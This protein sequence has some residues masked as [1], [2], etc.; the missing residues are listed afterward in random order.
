MNEP[1]LAWVTLIAIIIL[2]L[3]QKNHPYYRSAEKGRSSYVRKST[4]WYVIG[5]VLITYMLF[6]TFFVDMLKYDYVQYHMLDSHVY[7]NNFFDSSTSCGAIC[8][9]WTC[10]QGI[11]SDYSII[12]M[13]C[14]ATD[15]TCTKG[16]GHCDCSGDNYKKF[17]FSADEDPRC[18]KGTLVMPSFLRVLGL[19]SP[20]FGIAGFVIAF[21]QTMKYV[22]A[23][24]IRL[25][26]N[27]KGED[28]NASNQTLA[29][30][31]PSIPHMQS[32]VMGEDF[33]SSTEFQL[34]MVIVGMP[35]VFIVLS[36]RATIRV[37]AVMTG[38]C[39]LG[40]TK[41]TSFESVMSGR[42]GAHDWEELRGTW[43]EMKS[44]EVATYKQDLEVA[45]GFQFFA[46][47]CYGYV[48][49]KAFQKIM[50][51]RPDT[52]GSFDSESQRELEWDQTLLQH[53]GILG[54]WAFTGLGVLKTIINLACQAGGV[55][56]ASWKDDIDKLDEAFLDKMNMMFLLATVLSIVNMFVVGKMKAVVKELGGVNSKFNATRALLLIGQGQLMVLLAASNKKNLILNAIHK[57]CDIKK[58]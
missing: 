21:L 49:S 52:D 42:D 31:A 35:L 17:P 32:V 50:R 53:A 54:I 26:G 34:R 7:F 6:R 36:L 33:Q 27:K 25:R 48:V 10:P 19:I 47:W 39:M 40:S 38:S 5:F 22:H 13:P 41:G 16:L 56:F 44:A 37:W 57:N 28:N 11:I 9:D 46:V 12:T 23:R 51:Q 18:L 45:S 4:R 20:L 58:H 55:A 2:A 43:T 8:R 30:S 29:A 1:L 14:V 15:E 24:E 3:W